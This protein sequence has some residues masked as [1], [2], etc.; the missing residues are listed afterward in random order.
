[1]FNLL[2]GIEDAMHLKTQ[3]ISIENEK[4]EIDQPSVQNT[5]T[6]IKEKIEF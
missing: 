3:C 6:P 1:M 5:E 2:D 4:A